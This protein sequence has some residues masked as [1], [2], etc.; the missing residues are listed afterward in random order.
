M[1]LHEAIEKV[2]KDSN[3]PQTAKAIAATINSQSYYQRSDREPL[4]GSQVLARVKSYPT[5]FQNI[6]GYIFLVENESWKNILTSYWYL[7]N[8]LK[9]IYIEADVQ[10]IVSV[11]FY[12]KRLVDINERPG[13]KYP[14]GLD[15]NSYSS[16]D[17]NYEEG[18][19]LSNRLRELESF[20]LAPEGVFDECYR[21]LIKLDHSKQKE[22]WTILKKVETDRLNDQEFGNIFDYFLTLESLDNYKSGVVYTPRSLRELMVGILDPIDGKT[23][24]DPVA[25]TGGLLIDAL[26]YSEGTQLTGR[27]SEI[28]RR[29]AQLGNMNLRMHGLTDV[30]IEPKDCFEETTSDKKFDYI[31][32]DL[33]A[34]GITSSL[35]HYMLYRR[36]GIEPQKSSKSFASM[37]LLVLSK[38][39][40]DGKAVLT[41]SD[42]FLVK[43]GKE[44]EIRDLLISKDLLECVVSLPYGT[45]RPYT[46]AKASL[47]ILNHNKPHQL[48][49]SI[50]F[51]TARA[52]NQDAKSIT[53]NSDQIIRAYRNPEMI[54]KDAQIIE[55]SDLRPDTNLS[56]DAYDAQYMLAN[57][58][59]KEGT[60][61]LLSDL[62]NINSGLQ[63]DK[64]DISNDGDVPLV[65][66]ENL[67]K[68]ILDLTLTKEINNRVH[69]NSKYSRSVIDQDCVLI[70]RIGDSLKPTIFRPTTEMPSIILHG[71]VYGV[72]PI[73]EWDITLEY[74]YYQLHSSFVL[75]Q[76]EKRR[77]GAV[78]PSISISALKQI[79]L[80]YMK[81]DAQV[82]FVESQKATLIAE[83]RVRVEDRIRALGYKEEVKQT[84]SDVIKTLTHQLRPTFLGLDNL[85]HRIERIADKQGL[86][87]FKEYNDSELE[88]LVDPEL[89]EFTKRPD[90]YSL[91][92]LLEKLANDSNHLSTILSNV[93][94]V[95][96]FK[97]SAEDLKPI[98]IL[99]FLKKYKQQKE[100][101]INN[102]YS[103]IVKGDSACALINEGAF[104]ELLDQLL[105]NAERHGFTQAHGEKNYRAQF[106]VRYSKQREVVRIEYSNNGDPYRLLE[107]DFISAFEKGK[108]SKGSGIG[109]NYIF[110]IVEA[111][112]GQLRVAENY[113]KGFSLFIELP[114]KE[115]Q[116]Y[117]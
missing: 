57:S 60:G 98:D 111:H 82:A 47:L 109:G 110:R 46:D 94:K 63:P 100:I 36:Y 9:G 20:H 58:M 15:Q 89:A 107:K 45:L 50:K 29:V 42:G 56:A 95:M 38:L 25:G 86:N 14:I 17:F 117:E 81:L 37:I 71:N 30:H 70:A 8:T 43:K 84:E 113:E 115:S 19:I 68:D 73:N 2:L 48:A 22:I 106:T 99:S 85:V 12:Y 6:N 116:D 1:T 93:D 72:M 75:E 69:L 76:I 101:D 24:Y 53:L 31:I 52:I 39:K 79:V 33:P 114:A 3:R 35:E 102:R 28:N 49:N 21:L 108:Q 78:M 16:F 44:K 87:D 5:I 23:I 54:S 74:L 97:L 11:L 61:R 10:F 27:G 13:R 96:N 77:F 41:V 59:L 7:F 64:I 103:L 62:V 51:V 105:L 66:V 4:Q 67:S 104:K 18:K 26:Q 34:N 91:R 65:K 40:D 88:N 32:A 112:K 92:E 55:V 83:E 90:N 80:P